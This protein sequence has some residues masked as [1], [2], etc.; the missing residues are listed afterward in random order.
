M[1]VS[2]EGNTKEISKPDFF[3]QIIQ[4]VWNSPLRCVHEVSGNLSGPSADCLTVM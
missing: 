2:Y 4:A 1:A 3:S